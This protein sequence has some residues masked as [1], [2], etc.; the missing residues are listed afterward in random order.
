[1]TPRKEKGK[2][3][4]KDLDPSSPRARILKDMKKNESSF[5]QGI[6]S[7]GESDQWNYLVATEGE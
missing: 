3:K 7:D 2:K 5:A 6:D 1:M 4:Q